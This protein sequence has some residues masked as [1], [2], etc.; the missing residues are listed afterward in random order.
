MET[1][2]QAYTQYKT[3]IKRKPKYNLIKDEIARLYSLGDNS[4][5]RRT[6]RNNNVLCQVANVFHILDYRRLASTLMNIFICR[7]L[8]DQTKNK[9]EINFQ[10]YK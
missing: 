7:T 1:A 10:K 5:L 4:N 2:T 9:Q 6:K 3:Q 8:H